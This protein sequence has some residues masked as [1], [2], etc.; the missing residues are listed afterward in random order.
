MALTFKEN[1]RIVTD[2]NRL[3]QLEEQINIISVLFETGEL[4]DTLAKAFIALKNGKPMSNWSWGNLLGVVVM[5]ATDARGFRQWEEVNRKVLPDNKQHPRMSILVPDLKTLWN[6]QGDKWVPV[7]LLDKNGNRIPILTKN[8]KQRTTKYGK[9][10]WKVRKQLAG[11]I[12]RAVWD[13]TETTGEPLEI[14]DEADNAA[15][16]LDTLPMM[17]LAKSLGID[18]LP[19]S[20]ENSGAYGWYSS[21]KNT[22]GL[23]VKDVQTWLHELVHYA[24]D[25]LGNLVERGNQPASEAVAETG[26]ILLLRMLGAEE[27]IDLRFGYDYVKMYAD[28]VDKKP[29][30]LVKDMAPRTMAAVSWLL[31]QAE[32]IDA[33]QVQADI[34]SSFSQSA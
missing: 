10:M 19:Y 27:H 11:F 34:E 28:R 5:G 21:A 9:P 7:Y 17:D 24:D 8:G 22:I 20:G 29:E 3:A 30:D 15:Y 16:Y 14:D 31:D 23:G 25:A 13:I 4:G 2:E 6:K 33:E 1:G 26:S 32:R 12:V 18:V